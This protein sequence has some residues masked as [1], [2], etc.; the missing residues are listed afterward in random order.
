MLVL[1]GGI[2][3]FAVLANENFDD[4]DDPILEGAGIQSVVVP[5][6]EASTSGEELD[7][8]QTALQ[9]AMRRGD[10]TFVDQLIK[11]KDTP[12]TP[13]PTPK[14]IIAG[15]EELPFKLLD[16]SLD[17]DQ[18]GLSDGDEIRL[19]TNPNNPDTDGDGYID[20]L[21]II[22][23]Y[24][25]LIAGP[26]DK[27]EY[28]EPVGQ[29]DA[30]YKITGMRLTGTDDAQILTVTGTGPN[31]ALVALL[32]RSTENKTWFTRTDKTG[33]FLFSS[34][35]SLDPGYY[36]A[37]ASSVSAN[38]LPL[39]FSKP[40]EFERTIDSLIKKQEITPPAEIPPDDKKETKLDITIIIAGA[41]GLGALLSGVLT[42]IWMRRKKSKVRQSQ[43]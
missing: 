15:V 27:I 10:P 24:N 34:A 32:I 8:Y 5:G 37:Y 14:T 1:G 41:A 18:D 13:A 38:G 20:S 31:N 42:L 12:T 23:G 43:L 2:I 36:K 3:G 9:K 39:A 25:P 35:D 19:L 40:L 6:Q 28:K 21:E 16:I 11:R 4:D 22:R 7:Q 26:G 30:Q 17:R 33:R 29:P